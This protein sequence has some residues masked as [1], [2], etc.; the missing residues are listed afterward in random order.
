MIKKALAMTAILLIAIST[1]V[2]FNLT[3]NALTANPTTLKLYVSPTSVLADNTTYTC[4]FVQ[5]TDQS[6]NPTRAQQDI[7]IS[8][9]SSAPGIGT[10]D[11]TITIPINATYASANFSSTYLPGTTTITATAPNYATV[12]STLTT[13]GPYPYKT[14]VYGFPT[15][16]PADEGTYA[17]VMVQLQDSSG[18]PAR[19]PSNVTVSLFSSNNVTGSVTPTITIL[20]GQTF[21]I[22]NFT[23]TNSVGETNITA[24]GHGYASTKQLFTTKALAPPQAA[25]KLMIFKGP[26]QVL[27]DNNAYPQVAVQMQDDLGNPVALPSN[28]TVTIASADNLIATIDDEIT[29][30]AGSS[31]AVAT[32][33]TTYRAGDITLTAATNGLEAATEYLSA[34]GYTPSKLVVFC[35]PSGLPADLSTYPVI[36]VQLQDNQGRPARNPDS[37]TTLKLFSSDLTVGDVDSSIMIPFGRTLARGNF[38]FTNSSGTSTITAM[39]SNYSTGQA[40]ITGYIID[41]FPMQATLT[42]NPSAISA[43]GQV[44]VSAYVS[45]GDEPVTEVEV[46][47]SSNNGGTFTAIQ[48][49]EGYYNTTFTAPNLSQTGT[50]TVTVEASKIGWLDSEDS[51]QITVNP[52]ATPTPTPS[53]TATPSSTPTPT[54]TPA[55]SATSSTPTPTPQPSAAPTSDS[56]TTLQLCIKDIEGNPLSGASV[57]SIAQPEGAKTLS[58]V[59]NKT[60]YVSFKDATN[61]SYTFELTKAGFE[62]ANR[63]I[64]FNGRLLAYTLYLSNGVSDSSVTNP[65]DNTPILVVVVVLVVVVAVVA[66][67]LLVRR[68][69]EIKLTS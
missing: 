39:G 56:Q 34:V 64:T 41:F 50:C 31:Y 3:T 15:V 55:L 36:Q 69:W 68:R 12:T 54:P 21:A 63:T 24:V 11:P 33:K 35:A 18:Y 44:A 17:A 16:L 40:I 57:S 58:G 25:Q 46:T 52:I 30:L 27:A 48:Q 38:T 49:G 6:G 43:G 8:L 45:D 60:G 1:F 4:I 26:S 5:L 67:V 47:F 66:G 32:L 51:A 9:S 14:T 19:A 22:A 61:G 28:T 10:V 20:Q 53:P 7:T 2:S 29:V 59:T 65:G 62:Q 42:V 23:S 37:N 13:I